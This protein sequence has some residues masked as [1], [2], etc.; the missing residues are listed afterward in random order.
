MKQVVSYLGLAKRNS[1]RGEP[2]RRKPQSRQIAVMWQEHA[3][4]L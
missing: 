2:Q 4:A 3:P 1:L